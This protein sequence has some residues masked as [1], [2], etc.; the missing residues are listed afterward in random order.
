MVVEKAFRRLEQLVYMQQIGLK[1]YQSASLG[2][3]AI[4]VNARGTQHKR[5]RR[6]RPGGG[7]QHIRIRRLRA[8]GDILQMRSRCV[9][10]G[11][12][13]PRPYILQ[14]IICI[15]H[16]SLLARRLAIR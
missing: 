13:K 8:G 9:R 4:T 3:L 12:G 1:A 5:T 6:E 11:R 2:R 15:T 14:I 16:A 10:P 7:S